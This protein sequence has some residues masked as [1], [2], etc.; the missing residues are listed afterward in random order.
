MDRLREER[1]SLARELHDVVAHHVTGIVVQT[2]ALQLV[3][4]SRP[5]VVVVAAL[6]E[7]EQAASRS[8]AAMRQMVGALRSVSSD[9]PPQR[10]GGGL[11]PELRHIVAGA[12]LPVRLRLVGDVDGGV[13]DVVSLL[14]E[15][16]V[17]ESLVNVARHARDATKVEVQVVASPAAV[18]VE[19]VDDGQGSQRFV[20]GAGFGLTGLAERV[21]LLGGTLRVGPAQPSGWRVTA[22]V[23][24]PVGG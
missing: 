20:A 19:V 2:Q 18:D 24:L 10:C 4:S 14:V 17:T 23:P 13:P 16:V 11:G 9:L 7:L 5:E 1:V 3:A 15:R 6:P 22:T 12:D 21:R 8:L